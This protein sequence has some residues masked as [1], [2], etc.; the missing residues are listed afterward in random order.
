MWPVLAYN[1]VMLYKAAVEKAGST[2]AAKVIKAMEGLTIDTPMGS[3]TV[4]AKSHQT[5]TGQ[6]WGPMKKQSGEAYRRMEPVTFV[7]PPSK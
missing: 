6:F 7:P 1:G 3:L 2:D 4:D 5:N